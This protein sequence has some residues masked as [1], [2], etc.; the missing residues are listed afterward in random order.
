VCC[1]CGWATTRMVE[2]GRGRIVTRSRL[3]N[4]TTAR[5]SSSWIQWDMMPL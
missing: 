5:S 4:K 1:A 3:L 2:G